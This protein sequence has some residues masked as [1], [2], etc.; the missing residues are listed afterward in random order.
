[1]TKITKQYDR[2]EEYYKKLVKI[3]EMYYGETSESLLIGLKNL[4]T[5]KLMQDKQ[6]EAYEELDRALKIANKIY[7]SKKVKDMNIFKDIVQQCAFLRLQL[8][9]M[10]RKPF[11]ESFYN[12]IEEL[13]KKV[14]GGERTAQYSQFLFNKAKK[15]MMSPNSVP[16]ETLATISK[17]I[18][19]QDDLEKNTPKKSA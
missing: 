16:E 19:I 5:A 10:L 14:M 8:S 1:M 15:M 4:T 13:L 12:F 11:D 18:D 2:S 7:D 6:E 17:A 9:D 3:K